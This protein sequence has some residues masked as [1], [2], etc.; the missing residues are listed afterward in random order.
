MKISLKKDK[1]RVGKVSKPT[2]KPLTAAN[3]FGEV[4]EAQ[5][6]AVAIGQYDQAKEQELREQ[7]KVL[8]IER[9]DKKKV[10]EV[11]SKDAPQDDDDNLEFGINVLG[12]GKIK[13][14]RKKERV[15]IVGK[16]QKKEEYES[17]PVELFG[18]AFLRG[19]GWKGDEKGAGKEGD[20]QMDKIKKSVQRQDFL[21]IG[22]KAVKGTEVKM[23][24]LKYSPVVKKKVETTK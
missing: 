18:A 4:S 22:A 24:D 1:F 16:E 15:V 8:V 6:K 19:F 17:V 7:A 14:E 12:E 5:P 23:K 2:N 21:G 20:E 9:P 10:K 3:P 13:E 11:V